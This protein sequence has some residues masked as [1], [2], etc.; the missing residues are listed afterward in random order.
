MFYQ[1][2]R[3]RTGV[4]RVLHQTIFA[5]AVGIYLLLILELDSNQHLVN[6][7]RATITPSSI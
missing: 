3:V 2:L 6:W 7:D 5:P 4:N 1:L